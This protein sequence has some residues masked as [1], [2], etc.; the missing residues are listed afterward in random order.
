MCNDAVR[1][2]LYAIDYVPDCFK[3]QEMYNGAVAHSLCTLRL[4]SDHLKMEEMCIVYREPNS[5]KHVL[6]HLKTLE[7]CNEALAHNP[8]TLKFIP[9]HLKTQEMCD[10]VVRIDPAAFFLF[11]S[12]LKLK[13]CVLKL[14]RRTM[15]VRG[16]S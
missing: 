9:N 6:D 10:T 8:Y 16:L 1:R 12:V 15:S 2:E 7:T 11:L 4:I 13:R 5:F 3:T 14:L